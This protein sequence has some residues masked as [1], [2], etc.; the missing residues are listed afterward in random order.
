MQLGLSVR[1]RCVV[2]AVQPSLL[3]TI[4]IAIDGEQS[5][6]DDSISRKIQ[7]RSV[8]EIL[9]F[10]NGKPLSRF[11]DLEERFQSIQPRLRFNLTHQPY[12]GSE[13]FVRPFLHDRHF[14]AS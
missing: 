2:T 9:I 8:L 11:R 10:A 12:D 7:I 6:N 3:G 1:S 14:N 5:S 4:A 13:I